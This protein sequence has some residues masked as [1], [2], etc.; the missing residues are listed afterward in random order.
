M[1]P[2][3]AAAVL[4][5]GLVGALVATE[6]GDAREAPARAPRLV[7]AAPDAWTRGAR[8]LDAWPARGDLAGDRA[9][10]RRAA[11]AWADASGGHRA[12]GGSV[13]LLY[14]GRVDGAPLAVLRRGDRLARYTPGRLDVFPAGTGPSAPIALGGGRYLLAPW[15]ARAETLAGERLAVS[16]GVTAPAR[17]DTDC[18]RGPLFH[19]GSRTVGDLGG[20]RAAVLTYHSPGWR[21]RAQEPERLGREGRE[22][23]NRLACSAPRPARPVA[24]A[25]AFAFWSGRLPHGGGRADWVCTRLGYASGGSAAQATLLGEKARP[26]GA[27]DAGRP[28]S[29]TWWQAPSGSWYYLAAAGRGLVP[30]A[31]GVRGPAARRRLLVA[32][33]T[34][35]TPVVLTAR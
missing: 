3:A 31:D 16:G 4:T 34:P 32:T 13:R 35:R 33:G 10:V 8:T 30:H 9:F 24:E 21:P 6:H 29:G 23:W 17:A 14:A 11:A 12:S 18:G 15:H 7:S 20:P 25:M 1:L 26:T 2:L 5:A 19:L 28:V 22:V 27:C